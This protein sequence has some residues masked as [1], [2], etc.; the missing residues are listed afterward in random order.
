[1]TKAC[2]SY[3]DNHN[4]CLSM[5]ILLLLETL[6]WS[7]YLIAVKYIVILIAMESS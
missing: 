6:Y 1:M 7:R 5:Y 3:N 2:I 4:N